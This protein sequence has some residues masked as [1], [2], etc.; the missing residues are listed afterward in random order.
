MSIINVDVT[1]SKL[2]YDDIIFEDGQIVI[3][4]GE[5]WLKGRLTF[6]DWRIFCGAYP[7]NVDFLADFKK[8]MHFKNASMDGRKVHI[9]V[10]S[11]YILRRHSINFLQGFTDLSYQL[12]DISVSYQSEKE[13]S[14]AVL[15]VPFMH[16]TNNISGLDHYPDNIHLS[17]NGF[18]YQ[19]CNFEDDKTM[20]IGNVENEDYLD[21]LLVHISFFFNLIPN[22]FMKSINCKGETTAFYHSHKYP[23]PSESL[24]HSELPYI[25]IGEKNDFNFFLTTSS[26]DMLDKTRKT[27]LKNAIYSFSRCKYCDDAT[28][29]L[30]LYSIFDRFVGKYNS[31]PY[32][33][34]KKNFLS[35]NI[36]ISKIGLK[37][38]KDLQKLQLKLERG[39]N[40]IVIVDNFC[41]LRHYILH[42]MSNSD[43]DEYISQ[44]G[45]VDRMRFAATIVILKELGFSDV[46]FRK[47]WNHLSVM[48][49]NL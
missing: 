45:I 22:I 39:H 48:T 24:Y 33:E 23:F 26:W 18:D 19:L 15:D 4:N 20:L 25:M 38:D 37:T 42:F 28:Q 2:P 41:L 32:D 30:L 6:S 35:Y 34:M 14:F 16:L 7:A 27:I 36:D 17:K 10:K 44:S 29:F 9:N 49:A 11:A 40:K 12:T 46:K 21:N 3:E 8:C 47:D 31:D 43:T 1:W 13:D 5:I